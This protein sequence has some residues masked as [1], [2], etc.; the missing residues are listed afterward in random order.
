MDMTCKKINI[1]D[2]CNVERAVSEKKYKSGTC[3]IKLS[4]VDEFVGQIDKDGKI[5]S[6]F[7]VFE[8]K[9]EMDNAYLYIAINRAFPEFLR[10]NRTTINLQFDTLKNFVIDW[11]ESKEKQS[12]VVEQITLIDDAI[13]M[14]EEQI[15]CEKSMKKW[16][17]SKMMV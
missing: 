13:Q 4:A 14:L 15:E 12:Y 17:L 7:A 8:P 9:K 2:I 6:R 1:N 5:D 16:Y 10:R 3:Y 11:H